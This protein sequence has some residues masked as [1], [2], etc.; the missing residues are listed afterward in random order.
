MGR[1]ACYDPDQTTEAN[2]YMSSFIPHATYDFDFAAQVSGLDLS[3]RRL[4]QWQADRMMEREKAEMI[5][6]AYRATLPKFLANE[7]RCPTPRLT[8]RCINSIP[9]RSFV[10]A[11]EAPSP[12]SNTG[13]TDG[14][15]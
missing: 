14:R 13:P 15:S 12:S 8:L 5:A 2:R 3:S 4:T 9:V 7:Q 6:R 10:L 1:V 11:A